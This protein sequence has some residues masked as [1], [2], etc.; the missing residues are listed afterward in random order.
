MAQADRKNSFGPLHGGQQQ[1]IDPDKGG[2]ADHTPAG[3]ATDVPVRTLSNKKTKNSKREAKPIFG[4]TYYDANKPT[5][6]FV[7]HLRPPSTL[8]GSSSIFS[9][10]F[11][12]A[13]LL[14]TA[15]LKALSQ[16]IRPIP[17][18]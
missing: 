8:R 2:P 13:D 1:V 9:F 16:G 12:S 14:L 11:A 15:H 4:W 6:I 10:L 18:S 7:F 17:S 3:S 5:D